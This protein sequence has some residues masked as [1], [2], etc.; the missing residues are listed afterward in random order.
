VASLVAAGEPEWI[1]VPKVG[2][3]CPY[4]GLSKTALGHLIY[5]SERNDFKPPVRSKSVKKP[6]KGRGIRLVHWPSL[7]A[8]LEEQGR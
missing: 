5:P 3:H 4:T 6:G 7:K 8:Y 2:G 1:R